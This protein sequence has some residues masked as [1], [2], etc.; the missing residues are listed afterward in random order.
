MLPERGYA[1]GTL[2]CLGYIF[3]KGH[4]TINIVFMS[5][6]L[7]GKA[8]LEGQNIVETA[9]VKALRSI[10]PVAYAVKGQ[11]MQIVVPENPAG[12]IADAQ[13]VV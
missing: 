12:E 4:F 2:I 13:I 6:G 11:Q 7:A 8:E 9:F 1:T 5:A 3:C 10:F